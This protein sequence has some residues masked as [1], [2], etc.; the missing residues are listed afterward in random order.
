[1]LYFQKLLDQEVTKTPPPCPLLPFIALGIIS[2]GIALLSN[3]APCFAECHSCVILRSHNMYKIC[4]CVSIPFK[5]YF[6]LEKKGR[7]LQCWRRDVIGSCISKFG[8]RFQNSIDCGHFNYCHRVL[9]SFSV[10]AL[11]TV[12]H[13]VS[14]ARRVSLL[15]LF[16]FSMLIY[17]MV[18]FFFTAAIAL[19]DG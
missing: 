5:E 16:A 7:I 12:G 17:C 1:M 13:G 6:S 2:S 10:N 19:N 11:F 4:F 15:F 14:I 18:Y 8:P 3:S 9:V